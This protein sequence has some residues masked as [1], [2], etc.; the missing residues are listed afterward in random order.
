MPSNPENA[1]DI[2]QADQ[3]EERVHND[4]K[5]S[6]H[7][8]GFQKKSC[9]PIAISSLLSLGVESETLRKKLNPI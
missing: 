8:D 7:E 3:G 2:L 1:A 4:A 9:K 5:S 6:A